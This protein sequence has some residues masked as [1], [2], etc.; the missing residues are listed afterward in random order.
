MYVLMRVCMYV[1][2]ESL[3][4]NSPTPTLTHLLSHPLNQP[5]LK[6][7][8]DSRSEKIVHLAHNPHAEIAWYFTKTREQ[9][10]LS[11]TVQVVTS[12]CKDK[13]L[14]SARKHQWSCLSDGARV[15]FLWPFPKEASPSDQ[16]ASVFSPEPVPGPGSVPPE[17]FCLLLFKP[18]EID[19]LELKASP[20]RRTVHVHVHG[21][22]QGQEKE[23]E[24][25]WV[26]TK[27]NP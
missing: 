5:F 17:T 18:Q 25:E 1:C 19:H 20:Q 27:V 9:F 10:R 26:T 7:I 6:M 21:Q 12:T 16:D 13:P 24:K 15:Q 2:V 22:G 3:F 11:G 23:S 14:L 4:T 8:T